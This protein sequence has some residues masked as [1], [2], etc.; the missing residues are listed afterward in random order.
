MREFG[1]KE[2]EERDLHAQV[3]K[4]LRISAAWVLKSVRENAAFFSM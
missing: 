4:N 3:V 1:L 2:I